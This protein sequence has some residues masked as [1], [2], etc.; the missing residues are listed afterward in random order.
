M[1]RIG[2]EVCRALAAVHDAG[3]L[4]RDI[5]AQNVM[6]TADGRLVLMDFGTGQE[7]EQTP[8]AEIDM[9]GT[10][11]YLAPELFEAG[12]ATVRSDVFSRRRATDV[13]E[14]YAATIYDPNQ[15]QNNP[16]YGRVTSRSA[17]RSFRAALKI[18]F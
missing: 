6:Q 7:L 16:N 18:S 11:L 14:G 2:I 9:A 5:K 13:P 17:P 8:S 12:A 10:P 4:H 3:L 1:T 15:V